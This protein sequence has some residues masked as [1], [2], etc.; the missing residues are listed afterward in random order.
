MQPIRITLWFDTQ[1]EEK[2]WAQV[3]LPGEGELSGIVLLNR[4]EY[5]PAEA[6]F[7]WAAPLRVL[8][9]LDGKAWREVAAFGKAEPVFRV[10][11]AG[12]GI[13]ARHVRIERGPGADKGQPP[14]RFH[15]RNVL[16]Y[17]TKFY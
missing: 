14:G 2:P 11:L 4:Y 7:Q 13:K 5:A 9:S 10:D 12:K 8:V 6:E 17:G 16:V 1:A 15:F 3:Q